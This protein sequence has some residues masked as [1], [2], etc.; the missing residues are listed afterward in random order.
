MLALDSR[1]FEV[2]TVYI[3]LP[4]TSNEQIVHDLETIASTGINAI[5]PY[6]SFLLTYGKP[7]ARL[8]K[9]DLILKTAERLGLRVMPTVFWSGL[10]P[11]YA[12]AKWP[13]RFPPTLDADEREARLPLADP[14]VMGMIDY[15]LQNH[16]AAFQGRTLRD[17]LQHLGRAAHGGILDV[18]TRAGGSGR[19]D[20]HF[21]T[22][23]KQWGLKK[24]GSP[25]AWYAQWNDPLLNQ[26]YQGF[27]RPLF[28]WYATG[29]VFSI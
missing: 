26:E 10:I 28:Y 27:D 18:G 2:G 17:C 8:S 19:D 5:N 21:S 14:E 23:L 13:T 3:F 11:D 9:T 20:A 29:H 25:A 22:G 6:P 1:I 12:A 24:Y 7:R 15:L 4:S 16:R